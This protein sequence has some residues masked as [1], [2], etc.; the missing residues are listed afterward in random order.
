M[1]FSSNPKTSVKQVPQPP[2]SKSIPP[3]SVAPSFSK[4]ISTPRSGSTKLQTNIVSI[5]TAILQD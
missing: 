5:T 4:N 3:Y 1:K 2:I